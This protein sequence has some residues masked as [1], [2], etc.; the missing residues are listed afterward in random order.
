MRFYDNNPDFDMSQIFNKEKEDIT[1]CESELI[2][3]LGTKMNGE[4]DSAKK[5]E[6]KQQIENRCDIASLGLKNYKAASYS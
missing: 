6:L 3:E 1:Y 4:T 5:K 2:K